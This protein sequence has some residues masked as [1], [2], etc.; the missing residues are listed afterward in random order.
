MP[1]KHIP[2]LAE[3]VLE[4][5]DPQAGES[6]LDLTAGY[7]GHAR[8]IL[9]RTSQAKQS[10]LVDRDGFA[11][12]H[13]QLLFGDRVAHIMHDDFVTASK[14]LV[15]GGR[16]F[17]LILADLG[18]SSPHLDN[19]DRGFSIARP[20]PLDMRMDQRQQ[21]TAA[22]VVNT[23]TEHE[24]ESI[25]REYGEEKKAAVIAKAIVVNRPIDTTDKL[26]IVVAQAK[27]SPYTK[28]HPATKVFQALRIAVNQE[29]Q[30]LITAL[31]LWVELLNPGGRLGVITFHSL[32]DRIV[33]QFF[34][35][36]AG[37]RYDAQLRNVTKGAVSC[38][39]N[40]AVLNP[41]ARSAKLRVVA[42]INTKE[43]GSHAYSGKK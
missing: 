27:R 29:L 35:Q 20:G 31:P 17:D 5:L 32:E 21:L 39:K 42:K 36:Y 12:E 13:L 19:A 24:L 7:G 37:E 15:D 2:V 22:D 14:Q 43:R 26:A 6:Y 1:D 41:R 25:L 10:V 16:H 34:A 38:S 9:D 11:T 23:Y 30:Q 18:V 40:E 3:E 8:Q 4:Y 28:T 33:K